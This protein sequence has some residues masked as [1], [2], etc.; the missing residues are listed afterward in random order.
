MSTTLIRVDAGLNPSPVRM[1]FHH[2][3]FAILCPLL[4]CLPC[5]SLESNS[6]VVNGL[7][8]SFCLA[9]FVGLIW[10]FVLRNERPDETRS[11]IGGVVPFDIWSSSVRVTE[12]VQGENLRLIR[13]FCAVVLDPHDFQPNPSLICPLPS[14]ASITKH[15]VAF[16]RA[17][18]G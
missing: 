10:F 9:D 15:M 12:T 13:W 7:M 3:S 4:N 14:G 18:L 8:L 1:R 16:T 6:S 11:L 2:K 17:N 5:Q